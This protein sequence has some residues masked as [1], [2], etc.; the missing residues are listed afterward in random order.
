[1]MSKVGGTCVDSRAVKELIP[2]VYKKTAS[3]EGIKLGLEKLNYYYKGNQGIPGREVFKRKESEKPHSVLDVIA[4][5][6]YV[7]HTDS[8]ELR[9]HLAFRDYLR[10]NEAARREYENLKYAIAEKTK[11]DG[12]EREINKL[13]FL[14]GHF[15]LILHF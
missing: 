15:V 5:H 9:R 12:K 3:F 13:S 11:Q 8:K 10:E 2:I 14:T 4:H 1:M 6:L 7:C